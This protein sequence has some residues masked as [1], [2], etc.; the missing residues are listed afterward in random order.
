VL[1]TFDLGVSMLVMVKEMIKKMQKQTIVKLKK[2]GIK[3][4]KDFN[5]T[6]KRMNR[7]NSK[8]HKSILIFDLPA[9]KKYSCKFNCKAC[10]AMKAQR[11]YSATNIFRRLNF[12]L[13]KKHIDVLEYLLTEQLKSSIGVKAVRIHSSGDFFSQGYIDM[14]H[15]IIKAHKDI[16]F[17]A[18]T[19][20]ENDFNFRTIKKN[21]NFNLILSFATIDGKKVLNYGDNEHICKLVANDYFVC[22][23]TLKSNSKVI[24]G[25]DCNYCLH[26]DKVSFHQH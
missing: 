20:V 22:P 2:E 26:N 7:G 13:A 9:G 18:Y 12:E 6:V 17:Y 3:V 15:R 5:T 1:V 24:C 21:S 19:K 8:L 10:Y 4:S 23:A 11:Q 25:K 14:W 16:S